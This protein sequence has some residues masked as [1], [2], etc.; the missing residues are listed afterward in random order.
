ME[1]DSGASRASFSALVKGEERGNL[2]CEGGEISH[3][4]ERERSNLTCE[5]RERG[6]LTC[7]GER[8][9]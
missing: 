2:T 5:G 8:E 9:R 7:E 3:V 1:A 6:N 4:K